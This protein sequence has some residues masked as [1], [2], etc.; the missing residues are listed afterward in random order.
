VKIV[1]ITKRDILREQGYAV[2]SSSLNRTKHKK[3]PTF[4]NYLKS[5]GTTNFDNH[6]VLAGFIDGK[7]GGYLSGYAVEATAYFA[8]LFVKTEVLTTNIT[9]G[10]VFD[11]VQ[12][13]RRCGKISEVVYGLHSR[14]AFS[15]CQFK[16]GL[17]FPV[18]YIPTKVI[19]NGVIS[20][21]IRW[22]WPHK[23]YR[24]TGRE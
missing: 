23:Y 12:A 10:L 13:C 1:A 2:I 7:L 5:L 19:I 16:E 14:E 17:G 3:I 11:F 18:K 8:S 4:D 24:L 22:W 6:L 9:T 21:I 20:K 15:L